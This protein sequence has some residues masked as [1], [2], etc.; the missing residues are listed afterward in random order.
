MPILHRNLQKIKPIN[1]EKSSNPHEKRQT[2]QQVNRSETHRS[3]HIATDP[4]I[5]NPHEQI[6]EP[7]KEEMVKLSEQA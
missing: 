4:A 7:I 6:K 5:R 1:P 3:S 2:Q